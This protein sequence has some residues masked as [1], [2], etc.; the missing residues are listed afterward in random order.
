MLTNASAQPIYG[1]VGAQR[2]PIWRLVQR[3][4]VLWSSE[5]VRG[6]DYDLSALSV[7]LRRD[8]GLA[9]TIVPP[10]VGDRRY[11]RFL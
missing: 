5:P 3:W 2:S 9:Q 7:H 10:E 1:A 4:R 11:G 8:I 6:R